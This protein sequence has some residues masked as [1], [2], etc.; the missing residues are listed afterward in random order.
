MKINEIIRKYRKA[1]GMTQEE[2]AMRL[3]VTA[4]AV[5][6]WENGNAMPDITLL[7]PIARLLSVSLNELLSFKEEPTAE[8]IGRIIKEADDRFDSE[9]YDEAFAWAKDQ[10]E[11][12]P[13]CET[14]IYSLALQAEAKRLMNDI[15]EKPERDK[16]ILECYERLIKSS[17]EKIRIAAADAL[18]RYYYGKNML[19]KAE[20]YLSYL[21]FQSSERKRKTA[22]LYEKKGD[23]PKAF[24]IY[25][26]ILLSE[27]Q[28]LS[29]VFN[30]LFIIQIKEKNMEKAKYFADKKKALAQLF[31]M[32]K[33]SIFS[34]DLELAQAQKDEE[35]TIE[36]AK[37][38]IENIDSISSFTDSPL[39]SHMKFKKTD[40]DFIKTLKWDLKRGFLSDS[41]FDYMRDNPLWKEI[42]DGFDD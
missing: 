40:R 30:S 16:F 24:E 15:P 21:S 11:L 19:E 9:E 39:Y 23:L 2:M 3:G 38:I 29:M 10:T 6:K 13:N 25:E 8:E 20:E 34:A 36:C 14:L 1:K 17:D 31:E 32:G 5:N 41:G 27:Y 42:T 28:L 7:A 35:K 22:E 37:G 12:Y 26:E 4:P 18:Y 33:Y